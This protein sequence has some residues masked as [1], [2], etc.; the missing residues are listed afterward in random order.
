MAPLVSRNGF[1]FGFGKRTAVVVSTDPTYDISASSSSVNEGSSITFTITTTNV[2][3]GTT[4]YYTITGSAS[5]NDFTDDVLSGSFTI[6]NGSG[7]ISKT[8]RSTG[9]DYSPPE[10]PETFQVQI[11]TGSISGTIVVTSSTITINDTS[12]CTNPWGCV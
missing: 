7:T 6:T 4:L 11:R 2:A 8:A 5:S 9:G 1:S 3:S 12:S 10:G